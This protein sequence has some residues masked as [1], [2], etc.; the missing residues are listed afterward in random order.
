CRTS[1]AFSDVV[2]RLH[3]SLK[4]G[5]RLVMLE[6][7]HAGFLHRVLKLAPR[8]VLDTMRQAGFSIDTVKPMHF[9]P[10]RLVL[11][12][13]ETPKWITNTLYP[14]GE[15]FLKLTPR[16]FNMGDYTAISARRAR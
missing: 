10:T 5:G 9:W 11:T 12:V 16:V 7:F 13:G 4:P 2:G 3:R 6:P 8:E 15:F 14:L 1:E